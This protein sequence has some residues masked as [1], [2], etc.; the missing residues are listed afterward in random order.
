MI[1]NNDDTDPEMELGSTFMSTIFHDEGRHY[2][3]QLRYLKRSRET[4][5]FVVEVKKP[6]TRRVFA[7]D[8]PR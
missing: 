3:G 4:K 8:V 1:T 7:S 5:P 2:D 6:R